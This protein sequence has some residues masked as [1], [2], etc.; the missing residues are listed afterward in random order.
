MVVCKRR[1][2]DFP[3]FD[4]PVISSLSLPSDSNGTRLII[5][6]RGDADAAVQELKRA[7]TR[8]QLPVVVADLKPVASEVGAFDA[9][10]SQRRGFLGAI[11]LLAI[12]L[13]AIGAYGL[14]SYVAAARTKEIHIRIALGA[15]LANVARV[16]LGDLFGMAIGGS[17]LGL[18]AATRFAE[19]LN[20]VLRGPRGGAVSLTQVPL[21]PAVTGATVLLGISLL[22]SLVPIR[23]VTKQNLV[24][25]LR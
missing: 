23:R 25:G 2:P 4:I 12:M 5:R 9:R 21:A 13:A 19:I 3:I 10:A 22:G 17:M 7:M 20:I 14:S 16:V 18:L 11:S 8:I 24:T 6:V 1:G 15:P